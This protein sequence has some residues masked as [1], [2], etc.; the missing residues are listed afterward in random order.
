MTHVNMKRMTGGGKNTGLILALVL[1]VS[2]ILGSILG[3]VLGGILVEGLGGTAKAASGT[4]DI[5]SGYDGWVEASATDT[6]VTSGYTDAHSDASADSINYSSQSLRIGQSRVLAG[7]TNYTYSLQRGMLYFDTQ[8]L[9]NTASITSASVVLYPKSRAGN[10]V[11]IDIVDGDSL[12]SPPVVANY[13]YLLPSVSSLTSTPMNTTTDYVANVPYYFVL[14]A[15]ATASIMRGGVTRFGLRVTQDINSQAPGSRAAPDDGDIEYVEFYS[16]VGTSSSY[17]PRLYLTYDETDIG[18]PSSLSLF[19]TSVEVYEDYIEHGSVLIVFRANIAYPE[20]PS[21]DSRMYY[22]FSL[23][24][25]DTDNEIAQSPVTQWGNRPGCLYIADG[26]SFMS[27]SGSYLL[28]LVGSPNMFDSTDSQYE[29]NYVRSVTITDSYWQGSLEYDSDFAD[30]E[31]IMNFPDQPLS[32]FKTWLVN[33]ARSMG[34]YDYDDVDYYIGE[35]MDGDIRISQVGAP[36]FHLGIGSVGKEVPSAF[37]TSSVPFDYLGD[38]EMPGSPGYWSG[39]GSLTVGFD[40]LGDIVFDST[41][42]T[43][44]EKGR[45]VAAFLLLFLMVGVVSAVLLRTGNVAAAVLS[46][47][48]LLLLGNGM[49]VFP[50][51]LTAAVGTLGILILVHQLWLKST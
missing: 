23:T 21:Q 2:G 45:W 49:M 37:L 48:P 34:A 5:Y 22:Y 44:D 19:S 26:D 41:S 31:Y 43:S 11:T 3:G 6:N 4:F 20:V 40:R 16:S 35:T 10:N 14:N 13:G 24:D 39:F 12:L 32:F 30:Y 15:N 28:E 51:A 38:Y 46:I 50:W 36:Y 47:L 33:Q 42:M 1:S 7:G 8:D 25:L 9:P 27:S 17:W 18:T 29:A